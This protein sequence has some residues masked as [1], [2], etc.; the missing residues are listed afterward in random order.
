MLNLYQP[1]TGLILRL[2]LVARKAVDL[3]DRNRW[4]AQDAISQFPPEE[5]HVIPGVS[6]EGKRFQLGHFIPF[7]M[8][9][10][11]KDGS[12]QRWNHLA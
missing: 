4:M 7:D 6:F 1:L 12:Q 10:V 11:S 3:D 5:R 8:T 2:E 9:E